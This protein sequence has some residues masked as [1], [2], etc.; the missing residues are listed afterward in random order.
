MNIGLDKINIGDTLK[1][2]VTV[3]GYSA[4]DGW[5]LHYKINSTTPITITST[6]DGEAHSIL[7]SAAT[8][9]QYVAGTYNYQAYVT[10]ASGE[11]YTLQSGRV[12]LA[13]ISDIS[14]AR[15]V[16]AAIEATLEG[17]ATSDQMQIEVN[18][19]KLVYASQLDLRKLYDI[20]KADIA[21]EDKKARLAAGLSGNNK[22]L[23][24]FT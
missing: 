5:T 8:T 1:K 4:A 16:L 11:R 3:S 23:L 20:Y 13:S 7:V 19:R 18:G 14:H 12:T 22:V 10:N 24:R 2:S 6:A 17:R 9:A 15:K 21:A